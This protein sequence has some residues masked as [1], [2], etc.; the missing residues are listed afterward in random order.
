MTQCLLSYLHLA[1]RAA[2]VRSIIVFGHGTAHAVHT[3][4]SERADP[5]AIIFLGNNIAN[6]DIVMI[7]TKVMI[8]KKKGGIILR[9][10]I[11]MF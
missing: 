7:M 8:T 1:F 9:E 10:S 4:K 2:I 6:N 3:S 11:Y 5:L